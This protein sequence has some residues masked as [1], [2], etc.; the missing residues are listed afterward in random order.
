MI[1][2]TFKQQAFIEAYCGTANGNATEA[3]RRAGYSVPMQEGHRLLR[4]AKVKAEIDRHLNEKALAANEVLARLADMARASI[5]DVAT[6]DPKTGEIKFDF[7][8]AAENGKLH[9]I[10]EISFTEFGPKVKLHD[11]Q[12]ALIQLGRCHGLFRDRQ[13]IEFDRDEVAAALERKLVQVSSRFGTNG[14][15]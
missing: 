10:S 8:K 4:N 1:E 12:T 11:A 9:L 5:D 7:L 6:V 3:A 14:V 13:I 2:P 15:P